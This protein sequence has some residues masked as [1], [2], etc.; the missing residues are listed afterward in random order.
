MER[1]RKIQQEQ[2]LKISREAKEAAEK[3]KL[4]DMEK[5]RIVKPEK[6]QKLGGSTTTSSPWSGQTAGHGSTRRNPKRS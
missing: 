3:K 6:G 5:K 2:A 1:I 4:E